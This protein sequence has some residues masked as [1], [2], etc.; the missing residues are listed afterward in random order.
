M[1]GVGIVHFRTG[2][3]LLVN[4]TVRGM[5]VRGIKIHFFD[6][7]SPDITLGSGVQC[8]FFSENSCRPHFLISYKHV[9][10][11]Q[12]LALCLKRSPGALPRAITLRAFSPKS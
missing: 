4:R 5:M 6:K 3:P 1:I 9:P 11:F 7:H 8:A 10:P 2:A 12:G